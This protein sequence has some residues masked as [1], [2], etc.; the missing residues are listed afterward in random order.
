M[1]AVGSG[2]HT[3][4]RTDCDILP[5][6]GPVQ[7]MLRP[8]FLCITLAAA[9]FAQAP[10]RDLRLEPGGK[11]AAL[12]IGNQAYPKW[13]LRNPVNDA[14][15]ISEG[16]RA[17]GFE[18]DVVLNAGLRQLEQAVDR[19]V[20][21]IQPG[22]VALFYYAG[23][24]IQLAGENYLIPVDFD[25]KDEADAKYVS[26]SASRLQERMDLAGARLSVIILDACRNN[27]FRTTRGTGGG[28]AAMSTG[29]GTLIA[30]ATAPGQ[31]ADDNPGGANGLF[32]SHL[33][34]ALREPGLTLDQVFNRVRE[35]V[36]A[37]S[38][39]RQLPWTVS[40]VIG[41]YYFRPPQSGAP[42]AAPQNPL[43]RT[44]VTGNPLA[45]QTPAAAPTPPPDPTVVASGARQAYER[46]DFEEGIRLATEAT[47]QDASNAE[48]LY[49]LVAGHYRNQNYDIFESTA[50][51]ALAA[52]VKLP[53]SLAHH[54]TLTG[55]H[56]SSLTIGGGKIVFN[57]MDA[58]QCNQ[59]A[60]ELPLANLVDARQQTNN[61]G[62]IFLNV[63]VR[64]VDNKI[65]TLN[66]AD[67]DATVDASSGLPRVIPTPKSQRM[68]ASLAK[69]LTRASAK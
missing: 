3:E 56:L 14:Q 8:I 24:G 38:N 41:E 47:R 10:R 20:T 64:D 4:L 6:V 53:F 52:G 1:L 2:N 55:V 22:D 44:A 16:L 5:R 9:A 25:A 57:P 45:R 51:Q 50:A 36:Y 7:L 61:Q 39:Q 26:Y 68:L 35:R 43:V 33:I 23:H 37:D 28:L 49:V 13:P 54:H 42:A 34:S 66:F 30:F 31:T 69:V 46:G 15:A 17:V 19:F 11:T 58:R 48:A 59:K 60:F 29:K 63:R 67:P 27:P 40:S 18:P 32:T 65:R 12:V 62:E 21:R